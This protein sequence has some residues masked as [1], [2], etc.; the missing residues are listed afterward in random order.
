MWNLE[1][2]IVQRIFVYNAKTY[3]VQPPKSPQIPESQQDVGKT[4][5]EHYRCITSQLPAMSISQESAHL[6]PFL[7]K[8]RWDNLVCD[9]LPSDI[10]VW[11]SPPMPEEHDLVGLVE[12]VRQYYLDIAKEIDDGG[13]SWITVLCYINS[14]TG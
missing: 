14:M 11:I 4:V 5:I 8:Y 3:T 6:S 12:G 7:F 10:A 13:N 2:C 1:S 9:I